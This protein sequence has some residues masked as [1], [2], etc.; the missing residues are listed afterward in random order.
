MVFLPAI[1]YLVD[2]YLLSAPSAISANTFLRS[3][4]AAAFPLFATKMYEKLGTQWA[5]SLL[6]FTCL[7]LSPFPVLFYLYGKKIRSWSRYAF[8]LN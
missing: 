5:T 3:F 1:Q 6:A 4:V 2:T 8:D 7:G